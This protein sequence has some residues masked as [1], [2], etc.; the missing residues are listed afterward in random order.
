MYISNN[1]WE[2]LL[3]RYTATHVPYRWP[4]LIKS[5]TNWP[6]IPEREIKKALVHVSRNKKTKKD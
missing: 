2:I 4:Q 5:W 3:G 6:G 1:S